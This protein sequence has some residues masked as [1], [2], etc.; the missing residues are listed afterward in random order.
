MRWHC[1]LAMVLA[2]AMAHAHPADPVGVWHAE[3]GD[4]QT[5]VQEIAQRQPDGRWRSEIRI[6]A[7][8]RET[9]RFTVE[10]SWPFEGSVLTHIMC[11]RGNWLASPRTIPHA[12]VEAAPDM[13]R[14]RTQDGVEIV[15][16]RVVRTF[17]FPAPGCGAPQRG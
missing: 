4:A 9:E 5:R 12:V 14:L 2:P 16:P 7:D 3:Y 10:G 11:R 17:R 13:L 1:L 6:G 8:C 15:A